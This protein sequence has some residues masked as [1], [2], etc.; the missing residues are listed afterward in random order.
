MSVRDAVGWLDC[1]LSYR[2][3]TLRDV[4]NESERQPTHESTTLSGALFGFYASCTGAG[5]AVTI[6]ASALI[7]FS[8]AAAT[9]IVAT[10]AILVTVVC[11]VLA[12]WTL[13]IARGDH[14]N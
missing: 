7:V 2:R 14:K 10:I 9:P 6:A 11:S 12:W 13:G 3:S 1:I 5:V 8:D 4:A